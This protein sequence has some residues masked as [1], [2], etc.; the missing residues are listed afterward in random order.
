MQNRIM[1]QRRKQVRLG[2]L[3]IEFGFLTQEQL[4]QA[5]AQQ[6]MTKEPLGSVLMNLGFVTEDTLLAALSEQMN[7]D[8]VELV[9]DVPEESAL[10][11]LES[12]ANDFNEHNCIPFSLDINNRILNLVTSNPLDNDFFNE[13]AIRTGL[14]VKLKLAAKKDISNA[15][16]KYYGDYF[17]KNILNVLEL[18]EKNIVKREDNVE[19]DKINEEDAPMVQ[20]L[21]SIFVES[22]RLGSSDIHLEPLE[23]RIRVRYRVDGELVERNSYA[24]NLLNNIIT[25]IKVVGGMKLEEKRKPQDGRYGIKVDG[26]NYDIRISILPTTYG[27]K[28]V[29][30]LTNKERLTMD[31]KNLGLLPNDEKKFNSL[32]KNTN[33]IIL[34]TGPTG[35]GKS[36]TLYT[37]LS[38]LNKENVNIT[39][40]EDPVEANIEGLNQVQVNNDAGMSFPAA[41]RCFLRQDPDIIMVGEIRD[42]ET[43]SLAIDAA[44]TGHLVVST[45]HTNSSI[46][47]I[48]R[49]TKMGIEPYL[50]A[51]AMCGAL[52]QRLVKRLCSCKQERK[53]SLIDRKKLGLKKNEKV[54][55]Y[56]PKGCPQCNNTGY[57]G[58]I[59]IYEIL[60]FTKDIKE[61]VADE[62]P[63]S[64]V[65]QIA[66]EEGLTK[67]KESCIEQIKAGVTSME[68]MDRVVHENSVEFEDE[69]IDDAN[70]R[71]KHEY[72]LEELQEQVRQKKKEIEENKSNNKENE[73]KVNTDKSDNDFAEESFS[74]ENTNEEDTENKSAENK[75]ENAQPTPSN[76]TMQSD[77]AVNNTSMVQ[78]SINKE[79]NFSRQYTNTSVLQNNGVTSGNFSQQTQAVN[80]S[81]TN[82][83]MNYQNS[84]SQQN[85]N[86]PQNNAVSYSGNINQRSNIVQ[87]VNNTNQRNNANAIQQQV[88]PQSNASVSSGSDFDEFS[89]DFA[90]DF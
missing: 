39:T 11:Y 40:I 38:E 76:N 63:I 66:V 88:Q 4:Q 26:T 17:T 85:F 7:L 70:I 56:D 10:S 65:E 69:E 58:R 8:I 49:L 2:D 61:A 72:S 3:L 57:K 24:L 53:L 62:K 46:S 34:V 15:I 22:V 9:V 27:E 80:N 52:A 14:T 55:V 84:Q 35:S 1:L 32:L 16:Q 79:Q 81:F 21:N 48:S 83:G 78:Q 6:R 37:A 41:L 51:D 50:L 68:E 47:S 87:Q 19:V 77:N 71:E 73:E 25:R 13:L 90:N 64:F 12:Y 75:S 45:L 74:E 67:L 89:D 18:D 20:L 30:R 44:L 29:M 82:Q 60:M 33:G 42:R 59:A 31:K 43:A 28:A 54:K 86:A 36:T 5:L 23:D